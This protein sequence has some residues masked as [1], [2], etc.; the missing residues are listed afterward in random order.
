MGGHICARFDEL[1]SRRY[2]TVTALVGETKRS[3]R[4]EAANVGAGA[5]NTGRIG[6]IDGRIAKC[7]QTAEMWRGVCRGRKDIE[8]RMDIWITGGSSKVQPVEIRRPEERVEGRG[9]DGASRAPR[10]SQR[11]RKNETD[12]EEELCGAR[13]RSWWR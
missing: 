4:L 10:Q 11:G 8:L 6:H 1:E 12:G 2:L 7:N 9:L 5:G 13:R 3:R